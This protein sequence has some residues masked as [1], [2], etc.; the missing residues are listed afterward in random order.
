M[1][2]Q[3]FIA[4]RDSSADFLV[5]NNKPNN[6]DACTKLEVWRCLTSSN[7]RIDIPCFQ[8]L[9]ILTKLEKRERSRLVT[10]NGQVWLSNLVL[11]EED[12][13]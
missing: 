4:C 2:K 10:L 1:T 7:W 3:V 6:L 13:H 9:L 5:I 12:A 11:P 8:T